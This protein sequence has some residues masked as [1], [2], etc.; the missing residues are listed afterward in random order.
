LKKIDFLER[1]APGPGLG[2]AGLNPYI[3][4]G[5][6]RSSS[7]TLNV[8]WH[9]DRSRADSSLEQRKTKLP[10]EEETPPEK[11]KDSF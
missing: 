2:S 7:L 11:D 6:P 3:R 4:L 9:R 1:R 5:A 8:T 10:N